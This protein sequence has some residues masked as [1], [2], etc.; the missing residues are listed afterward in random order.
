MDVPAPR[1][2]RLRELGLRIGRF[3]AGP[4]N[5]ITDVAGVAV[6]HV[7]IW[8]DEPAPPAGRGVARTG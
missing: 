8:R 3:E 2:P 6:G 7:T 5:A 4:S 1:G